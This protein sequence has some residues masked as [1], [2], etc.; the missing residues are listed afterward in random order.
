MPADSR[1]RTREYQLPHPPTHPLAHR[2][3]EAVEGFL[4]PLQAHD[5]DRGA[6]LNLRAFSIPPAYDYAA[7]AAPVLLVRRHAIWLAG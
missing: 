5:W 1:Q 7:L 6:L 3:Q 2:S 4:R